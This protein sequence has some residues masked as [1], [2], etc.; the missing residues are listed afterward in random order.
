VKEQEEEKVEEQEEDTKETVKLTEGAGKKTRMVP[1][2]VSLAVGATAS[3]TKKLGSYIDASVGLSFL[4]KGGFVGIAL[5]NL[6]FND[7]YMLA[8]YPAGGYTLNVWKDLSIVFTAGFGFAYLRASRAGYDESGAVVVEEGNHW[9]LV[10]HAD[11]RLRYKLGPVILQAI[12]VHVNILTGVG[13]VQPAPLAQF[14][15][16]VGIAY[17][18]P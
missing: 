14:A 16:L 5:D 6:F 10:A 13:S 1:I 12:P 2:S 11:V 15:F 3:T 8:A 9:D 17:E 4:I 7:S 18:Y